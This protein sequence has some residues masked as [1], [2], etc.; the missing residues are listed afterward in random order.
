[1]SVETIRI[2]PKRVN[3]QYLEEVYQHLT[4]EGKIELDRFL[5]AQ[6]L[7]VNGDGEIIK[8][9]IRYSCIPQKAKAYLLFADEHTEIWE[10][11][12]KQA[13]KVTLIDHNGKI[14]EDM[15]ELRP[16]AECAN[17]QI[18]IEIELILAHSISGF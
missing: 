14:Y 3:P 7:E 5:S 1:M 17:H 4:D 2:L 9:P 13:G 15:M 16:T 11:E 8:S 6:D 18:I 12:I 10:A